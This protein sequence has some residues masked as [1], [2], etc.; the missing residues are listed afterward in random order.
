MR[1][2]YWIAGLL[3]VLG[4][5]CALDEKNGLRQLDVRQGEVL[6]TLQVEIADDEDE[7]EMGLMF[8]TRM[9]EDHGML[10]V[11]PG[12]GDR[13]FWMKNT[14]IPL[15]MLFVR[16]GVVVAVVPWARP[17]DEHTIDP[18][19]PVDS[20]LEVNGGWTERNGIGKG[21]VLTLK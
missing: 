13:A 21:A 5:A 14:K 18:G 8:R 15:D 1:V 16:D 2:H 10:F 12:V 11:W 4:V 17:M 9:A 3:L 20:V 19:V 6:K 7:R